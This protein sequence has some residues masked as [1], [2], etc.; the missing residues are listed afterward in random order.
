M[1]YAA[2]WMDLE[3]VIL[4]K[5][6]Q[7]E[8]QVSCVITCMWNLKKM[9]KMNLFTKKKQSHTCRKQTYGYQREQVGGGQT[10]GLGVA[11]THNHSATGN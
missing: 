5:V 8:W 7:T 4:S 6:G 1:P 11:C 9:V 3:I 2:K 10:R